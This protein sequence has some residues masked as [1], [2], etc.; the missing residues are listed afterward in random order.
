MEFLKKQLYD[1]GRR[2]WLGY[3]RKIPWWRRGSWVVKFQI[4]FFFPED[5]ELK[6]VRKF[7]GDLVDLTLEVRKILKGGFFSLLR[8]E[9]LE[10]IIGK[11]LYKKRIIAGLMVYLW[12]LDLTIFLDLD[13]F[14]EDCPR[15]RTDELA[16]KLWRNW[17]ILYALRRRNDDIIPILPMSYF[18]PP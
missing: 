8:R 18:L 7:E 3:E 17:G 1:G 11:Y 6:V 4:A 15:E 9:N 13:F 12:E 16:E 10:K 14:D 5:N 2:E